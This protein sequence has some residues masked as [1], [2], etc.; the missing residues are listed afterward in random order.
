MPVQPLQPSDEPVFALEV[1]GV[2]CHSVDEAFEAVLTAHHQW[3]ARV[4][5]A[6]IAE[7][8]G[9]LV[10]S[11]QSE[12]EVLG[13]DAQPLSS[14]GGAVGQGALA[15]GGTDAGGAGNVALN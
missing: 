2:V 3:K 13:V 15:M 8:G 1:G 6:A 9:P 12:R 11:M 7:H 10:R 4:R 14:A 5:E